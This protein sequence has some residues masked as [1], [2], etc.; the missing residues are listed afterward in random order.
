M[1]CKTTSHMTLISPAAAI[2]AAAALSTPVEIVRVHG[3]GG[4]KA[5][6]T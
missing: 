1:L 3:D 5:V 4:N 6:C 2:L